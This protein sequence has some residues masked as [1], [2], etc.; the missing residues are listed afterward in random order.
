MN[1]PT[2]VKHT[3]ME[4]SRS[5]LM[6]KSVSFTHPAVL[7]RMFWGLMSLCTRLAALR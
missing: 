1:V 4:S 7:R 6:P 2:K 5:R 3:P